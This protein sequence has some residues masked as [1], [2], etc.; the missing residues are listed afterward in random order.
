MAILLSIRPKT[1]LLLTCIFASASVNATEPSEPAD[2]ITTSETVMIPLIEKNM[3]SSAI[4]P[5]RGDSQSRVKREFGAPFHMHKP[6]GTP[7]ISRWDFEEFSVYFES[8]IVI[9]TVLAQ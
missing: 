8:G 3:S 2:I 1:L 7:P 5:I 9:H 6:K 4:V